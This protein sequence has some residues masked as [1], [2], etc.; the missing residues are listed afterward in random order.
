MQVSM[1]LT[2][3]PALLAPTYIGGAKDGTIKQLQEQVSRLQGELHTAR[4]QLH[5][6]QQEILSFQ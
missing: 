1:H 2:G 6:T 3:V 5:A 4:D